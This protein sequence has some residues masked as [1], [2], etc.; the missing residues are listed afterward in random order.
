M[1][2]DSTEPSGENHT[3]GDDEFYDRRSGTDRRSVGER[4]R[5]GRRH[6]PM[7]VAEERRT[8]VDQRKG[9]R[10]RRKDRR[11]FVDPR[12]K[13]KRREKGGSL[14]SPDDVAHVQ[15]MLSHVGHG[16][17]CPVCEGPF[18]LGPLNRLGANSVRQVW[19]GICGR[20]TVVT[21]CVL[22]RV[23]VLTRIEAVRQSLT[24]I[25]T[26]AGHEILTPRHTGI[27]LAMYRENP[28]DAVIMDAVALEPMDGLEFIR[29]LRKEFPDPY[30]VVISPPAS[31]RTA[32]PSAAATG[33]G[34]TRV[35]RT[36]FTKDEIL[37]VLKEVRP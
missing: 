15:H 4:R 10:R 24:T 37:G 22:V 5:G 17:T 18:M 33:L 29:R 28:A 1:T 3:S 7:P 13:K 2:T 27:A 35:V 36:P 30:V 11:R 23:M 25:L 12:Y 8:G 20:G 6:R 34:A 31:Y 14:Y 9:P 16:I 21:N 26:G 32:D 19:C